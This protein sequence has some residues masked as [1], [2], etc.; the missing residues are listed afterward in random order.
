MEKPNKNLSDDFLQRRSGFSIFDFWKK[1][2][3]RIGTGAAMRGP[4]WYSA[5]IIS[6]ALGFWVEWAD[7]VGGA[8]FVRIITIWMIVSGVAFYFL[9]RLQ[10]T[11]F[12][13]AL[14]MLSG[15]ALTFVLQLRYWLLEGRWPGWRV[16]DVPI[17]TE[18]Q[19]Q[20]PASLFLWLSNQSA[21]LL[22]IA[23]AILFILLA[24]ISKR[25]PSH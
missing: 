11:L 23:A 9:I 2:G 5:A 16:K 14:L 25:I 18:V 3:W 22:L 13:S 8:S 15:A 20:D 1:P 6:F 24:A 19:W 10:Q 7:I 21:L 17:L 12:W 4:L